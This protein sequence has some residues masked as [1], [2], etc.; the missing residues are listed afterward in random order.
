MCDVTRKNELR[1]ETLE[2]RK[3][4]EDRWKAFTDSIPKK[5][6]EPK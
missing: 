4:R 1:I 2:E 6:S 5:E 3:L